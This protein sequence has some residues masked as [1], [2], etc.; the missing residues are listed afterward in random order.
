[1]IVN[2]DSCL[3]FLPGSQID[4]KPLKNFEIDEL[5][6]VPLKF[7]CVKL[8]DVRGNIV[9]SR[10]AILEESRAEQRAE[11]VGNLAEGDS[12]EGIVKNITEYGA[13]IDLGGIDGLLHITDLSWGRVNHPSEVLSMNDLI[14][15]LLSSSSR[16]AISLSRLI[17][18]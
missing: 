9:V 8:D 14:K 18:I 4:T 7:L 6:N 5:M 11:V 1:M 13:F 15:V 10:R 12:V 3:C 2:I 16:L 17:D